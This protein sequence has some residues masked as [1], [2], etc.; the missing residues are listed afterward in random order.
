MPYSASVSIKIC[1]GLEWGIT[2]RSVVMVTTQS[3]SKKIYL[4]SLSCLTLRLAA[5]AVTKEGL[6]LGNRQKECHLT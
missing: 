5:G 3:P 4:R 6:V 2:E 1:S